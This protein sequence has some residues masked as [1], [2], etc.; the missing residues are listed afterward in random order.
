MAAGTCK[1]CGCTDANACFHPD[2]GPCSWAD[3]GTFE[4]C[5]FC[6][7]FPDDPAVKRPGDFDE[8]VKFYRI[9]IHFIALHFDTT[10]VYLC[11][12]EPSCK[13]LKVKQN[14]DEVKNIMGYKTK[15]EGGHRE[16]ITAEEF[17]KVF[18]DVVA[19]IQN[20]SPYA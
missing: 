17:Q 9:G 12:N 5:S 20:E 7:D 14:P 1:K 8:P 10:M 2:Y 6:R 13:E 18:S 16:E 4:L 3:P 19:H 15:E 11:R